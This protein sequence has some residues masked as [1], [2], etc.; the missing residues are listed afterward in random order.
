MASVPN[1]LV[2][3]IPITIPTARDPITK[4]H[5]DIRIYVLIVGFICELWISW[6]RVRVYLKSI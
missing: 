6:Q 4:N 3:V 5:I 1:R 2:N